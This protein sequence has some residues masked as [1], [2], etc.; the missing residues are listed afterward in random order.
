MSINVQREYGRAPRGEKVEDIKHGKK[1]ERTN[2]IGALCNGKHLGVTC[3]SHS[4]NSEFFERWFEEELLLVIPQ[5]YT[6]IMDNASFHRKGKL[7]ELAGKRNVF[8]EFLP[9]YSPDLN[10][11]E[12]SWANM[13]RYLRDNLP[14]FHNVELAVD[15]F[16][17][18]SNY[19][20]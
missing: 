9:A 16:F 20:C 8:I 7:R 2:V 6:V 15:Y 13:K 1:A 12:K 18:R 14:G 4:T 19:L 10:P 11:I 17:F 5:G 3:Y